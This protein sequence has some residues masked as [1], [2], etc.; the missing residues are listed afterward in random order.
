MEDHRQDSRYEALYTQL[1]ERGMDLHVN[2]K[3]RIRVGLILLLLLPV[4]LG[5]ILKVTQSDKIVFLIIWV[6]CMFVICIYLISIE[7]ID[8]SVQKTL[9]EVTERESGFDELLIDGDRI[10]EII[11]A[12]H[13]MIRERIRALREESAAAAENAEAAV[14]D[15]DGEVSDATEE[16]ISDPEETAV[17]DA[18]R[19]ASDA[20]DMSESGEVTE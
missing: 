20:T 6:I 14:E 12:R 17:E 13:S 9:E 3:K 5:I 19:E 10:E 2:N 4:I 18:D 8:T 15:A 11:S 7:Y 16:D 1:L